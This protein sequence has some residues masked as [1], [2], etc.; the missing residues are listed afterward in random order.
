[1]INPPWSERSHFPFSTSLLYWYVFLF[2][3]YWQLLCPFQVGFAGELAASS[4]TSRLQQYLPLSAK[5]TSSWVSGEAKQCVWVAAGEG[6]RDDAKTAVTPG[7]CASC[8]L[9]ISFG[10]FSTSPAC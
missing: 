5:I 10:G 2:S 9:E 7:E 4:R 3:F 1:M 6:A 8:L